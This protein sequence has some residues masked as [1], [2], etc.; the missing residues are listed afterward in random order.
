MAYVGFG[1]GSK[2]AG[3]NIFIMYAN[4]AGTNVTLS[5]RVGSGHVQPTASTAS[6]LSLLAGSGISDG[7]MTAN[8]LCKCYM[9]PLGLLTLIDISLGSSCQSWS[10]G[11][12]D[13]TSTA[14]SWIYGYKTGNA[15]NTNSVSAT[16]TQHDSYGTFSLDLATATGGNSTNPF[17]TSS[18]VTNGTTSVDSSNSTVSNGVTSTDTEEA[19]RARMIK[20]H[21][22]M[23]AATFLVIFPAGAIVLRVLDFPGLIWLHV[24]LQLAGLATSIAIFVLGIILARNGNQVCFPPSQSDGK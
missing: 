21:G 20:A 12:M 11:T 5:P 7:V 24:A 1:Q 10:G 19:R 4:A 6:T 18:A 17:L 3:S 16:I 2:M 13:F 23:G 8:V 22:L 9:N 14:T 15:L